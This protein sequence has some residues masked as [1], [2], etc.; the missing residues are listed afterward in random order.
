MNI[1]LSAGVSELVHDKLLIVDS[2]SD[3]VQCYA[4]NESGH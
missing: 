1:C 2:F 3:R 4:A